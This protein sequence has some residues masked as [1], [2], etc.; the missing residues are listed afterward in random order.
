M[1]LPSQKKILKEDLKD[2][3]SW[4]NP[5]LEVVN[6]FMENVYQTLNR[7]ISFQDNINS[8]IKLITIKT[9]SSYPTMEPVEFA[10]TLK[11]KPIGCLVLQAYEKTTMAPVNAA[12]AWNEI[13]GVI[14]I[15]SVSG[16]SASSSYVVRLLVI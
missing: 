1:K 5:L 16:L 3:P 2:S 12:I 14:T 7:N 4:V 15:T 9:T 11:T 8:Q 6:S 13:N 10:S